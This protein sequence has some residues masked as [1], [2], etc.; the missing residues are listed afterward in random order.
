MLVKKDNGILQEVMTTLCLFSE[1]KMSLFGFESIKKF[2]IHPMGAAH[3][4]ASISTR[5]KGSWSND[6][7][8]YWLK[9]RTSRTSALPPQ[10]DVNSTNFLENLRRKPSLFIKSLILTVLC[11]QKKSVFWFFHKMSQEN[12]NE[13]FGQPNKT[14][15]SK[16]KHIFLNCLNLAQDKTCAGV[17]QRKAEWCSPG[18]H[19]NTWLGFTL[20]AAL[21][22][23]RGAREVLRQSPPQDIVLI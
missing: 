22:G 13:L 12:P 23:G 9:D 7:S 16:D 19:T 4:P 21:R 10:R 17:K 15:T 11:W 5:I 8:I 3:K 18:R 2:L 1:R 14:G 6:S 20:W